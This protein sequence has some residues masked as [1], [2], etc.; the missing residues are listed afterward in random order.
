MRL[1]FAQQSTLPST[2]T[3]MHTNVNLPAA[4]AALAFLGTGFILT[5]AAIVLVQS[6][7]ARKMGRARMSWW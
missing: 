5:V 3:T 2:Y 1:R 7:F 6:L 4:I